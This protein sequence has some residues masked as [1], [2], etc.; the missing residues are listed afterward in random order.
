MFV[1]IRIFVNIIQN[2]IFCEDNDIVST[3]IVL[4][5]YIKIIS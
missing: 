4:N 5:I 3:N 1:R 2:L